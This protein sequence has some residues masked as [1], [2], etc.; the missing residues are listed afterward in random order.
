MLIS[1]D[2]AEPGEGIFGQT[3]RILGVARRAD[4]SGEPHDACDGSG[5]I[6]PTGRAEPK[7]GF[8]CRRRAAHPGAPGR[9]QHV[10]SGTGPLTLHR[11]EYPSQRKL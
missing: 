4:V 6:V 8:L 11:G 5:V 7:E 9:P 10:R 2:P 1:Q 3:A